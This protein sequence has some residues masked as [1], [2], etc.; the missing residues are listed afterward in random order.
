MRMQRWLSRISPIYPG[1]GR[2]VL[3]CL[4]VN[5]CIFAGIMFGRNSRDSLFLYYFG[6]K[7]LPYMYFANA[8]S[9]VGCSLV[10]TTLVDRI[11]RGKFLAA[12][13]LLFVA[14]LVASRIVLG[15]HPHWFFPVLYVEA[16][17]IWIFSLMQFWT[18]AGDL[19]DTRQAK[20]LFPLI[21]VGALMGMIS[22][23]L[24][25]KPIIRALGTEN[26]LLIWA[27]LNFAALVLGGITYRR[28]RKTEPAPKPDL[29]AAAAAVK[30]SEWQKIKDG[31]R[32]LGREP[33]LRS[34]GGYV[35]LLWTVFSI[36]DFCY[37]STVRSQFQND[38]NGM[39][40]FLGRFVGAQG[41]CCLV[42][43][44]LLTR[45][46]IA[47]LGVGTTINFHPAVRSWAP[48]G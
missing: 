39:T 1:E 31:F 34:M 11:E 47:R 4:L 38:P 46:V 22:V 19:F 33:L 27:G 23:G 35:F 28:Y 8:F 9:L 42:V 12:I 40:T 44:L 3:L 7:Y 15:G 45:A 26:L 30:L 5:F 25:C 41:L 43:Q 29:V 48:P 18:F 17:V 37:S 36:V 24:F 21:A 10:Y 13:S 2:V 20:R 6:V 16:Q 32:D 14:A